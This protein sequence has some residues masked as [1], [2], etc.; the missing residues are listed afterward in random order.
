MLASAKCAILAQVVSSISLARLQP[1]PSAAAARSA[2]LAQRELA[3][4]S[5]LPPPRIVLHAQ[6]AP[7][8]QAADSVRHGQ[9]ANQES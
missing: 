8:R 9:P 2:L 5:A 1:I 7:G 3:S 4:I 6:L